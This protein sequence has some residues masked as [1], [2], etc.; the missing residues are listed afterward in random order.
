MNVIMMA[1]IVKV[2]FKKINYNFFFICVQFFD[3]GTAGLIVSY[4][5]YDMNAYML[6]IPFF[7]GPSNKYDTI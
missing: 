1:E 5:T 7:L 3:F 2:L 6:Y 4:V